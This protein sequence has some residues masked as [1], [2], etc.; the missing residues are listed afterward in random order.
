M[1]AFG[2]GAKRAADGAPAEATPKLA[3]RG[4][5]PIEKIDL[6]Q[7]R[8]GTVENGAQGDKFV[9]VFNL[10]SQV[11]IALE[12]H[13]GW[14][15][16][17]FDAGPP[18]T[19]DGSPLSNSWGWVVELNQEAY[20]KMV[21]L[22]DH[23]VKLVSPMRNELLPNEAKKRGKGGLTEEQFADK[24]NSK[25][26]ASNPEKGYSACMRIFI[27]TDPNKQMPKIQKMHLKGGK[28]TRPIPGTVNDLK[29]G[30]ACVVGISLSRGF[31]GGQT[32]LGCGMKWVATTID[33]I[34]NLRTDNAPAMDYSGIEFLDEETPTGDAQDDPTSAPGGG[35][36]DQFW[37]SAEEQPLAAAAKPPAA[38]AKPPAAATTE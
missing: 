12:T 8:V 29:K 14:S 3:K 28:Y 19:A 34:E 24:F 2:K 9:R 11:Q 6:N 20:D 36:P 18:K 25:L 26:T 7:I 1:S 22:E 37:D 10:D 33:L 21:K 17:P 27:E 13:P 5:V 30:S 23:V 15:R 38:A 31:Y 35:A 16:A 32:G 4:M